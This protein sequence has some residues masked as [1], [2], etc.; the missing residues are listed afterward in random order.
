M[1][2]YLKI[3]SLILMLVLVFQDCAPEK[4]APT[5]PVNQLPAVE[6]WLKENTVSI[7]STEL[8]SGFDDLMPLKDMIGNARIVV[9]GESSY[10]TH[11]DLAIKNRMVRFLFSEMGFNVLAMEANAPECE[12]INTFLRTGD[13]DAAYLINRLDDF[14]Y[15]CQENLDYWVIKTEE[16]LDLVK[17]MRS[18]NPAPSGDNALNLFGIDAVFP[19]MAIQNVIYYLQTV[20]PSMAQL[21]NSTYFLYRLLWNRCY[22]QTVSSTRRKC[23]NRVQAVYD[24]LLSKQNLYESLSSPEEFS[25]ALHNARMV[26]QSERIRAGTDPEAREAFMIENLDYQIE[27]AGPDAKIIV[28]THNKDAGNFSNSLGNHLKTKYGNDAVIFGFSFYNGLFNARGIDPRS[29]YFLRDHYLRPCVYEAPASP[30]GSYEEYLQVAGIP[31]FLLDLRTIAQTQGS[32]A[33]SWIPGPRAFR[34]LISIYDENKPDDYF[35]SVEL[36]KIFDALV[37]VEQTSPSNLLIY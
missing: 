37:F 32:E 20:D 16:M 36:P 26:I 2:F 18:V 10:G 3:S 17:W 13:G 28:W 15:Y 29:R 24:S 21:A 9:L 27:K 23:R 22:D 35:E 8:Q 14:V 33:T 7:E 30:Q 11:E 4:S 12:Q 5:A 34:N 19:P 6:A 31:M 1:K 25:W